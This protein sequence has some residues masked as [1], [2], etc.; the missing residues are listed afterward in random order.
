[1][2]VSSSCQGHRGPL[3]WVVLTQQEAQQL[4]S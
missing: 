2:V 4:L 3:L 1:M